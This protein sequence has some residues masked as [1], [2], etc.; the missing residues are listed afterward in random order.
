MDW[1]YLEFT[2]NQKSILK[3]LYDERLYFR[4]AV[5]HI[6]SR[7]YDVRFKSMREFGT[8]RR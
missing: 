5:M 2:A 3:T 6:L 1:R 8:T 7:V 4:H